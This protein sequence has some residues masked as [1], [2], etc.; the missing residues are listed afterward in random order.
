MAIFTAKRKPLHR[1]QRWEAAV[2]I[3]TIGGTR[4]QAAMAGAAA[5]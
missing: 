5:T 3:R 2:Y 4:L 1:P